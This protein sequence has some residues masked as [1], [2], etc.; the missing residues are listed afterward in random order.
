MTKKKPFELVLGGKNIKRIKGKFRN[1]FLKLYFLER[2]NRKILLKT[3]WPMA[4]T[5]TNGFKAVWL[6]PGFSSL[7]LGLPFGAQ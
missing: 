2:Q 7:Y 5:Y 6:P 4:E 3:T 1:Y